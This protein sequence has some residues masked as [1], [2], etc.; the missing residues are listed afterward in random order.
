MPFTRQYS[1]KLA[2]E[3]ENRPAHEA[4]FRQ[5]AGIVDEETR[6]EI[7]AAVDHNVAITNQSR[8]VAP[9]DPLSNCSDFRVRVQCFECI[10][11]RNYLWH[12]D[13][14]CAVSD[15][16]LEVTQFN[17]IIIDYHKIANA[18]RREI[19]ACGRAET[20]DSDD[21]HLRLKQFFLSLSSHTGEDHMPAISLELILGKEH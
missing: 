9:G 13:L 4:L 20:P 18:G 10:L 17:D 3:P 16:S 6:R 14:C 1:C 11:C 8:N 12:A 21:K 7:I 19:V 15:L 2:L 5:H